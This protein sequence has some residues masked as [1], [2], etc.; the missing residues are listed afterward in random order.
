MQKNLRRRRIEYCSTHL[1]AEHIL[2]EIFDE[3]PDNNTEHHQP[4]EYEETRL[5]AVPRSISDTKSGRQTPGGK[6]HDD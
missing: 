1:R 4:T 5:I 6:N 3:E 2:V